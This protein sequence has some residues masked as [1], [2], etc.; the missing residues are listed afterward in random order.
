MAE[1]DGLWYRALVQDIKDE[2]IKVLK[3]GSVFLFLGSTHLFFSTVL[4]L[5]SSGKWFKGF[6]SGL[7]MKFEIIKEK[8]VNNFLIIHP[9]V[10][11][12]L[13]VTVYLYQSEQIV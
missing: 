3:C 5:Q 6:G 1:W 12:F 11:Y 7:R 4:R 10:S 9:E 2:A 13:W 8:M